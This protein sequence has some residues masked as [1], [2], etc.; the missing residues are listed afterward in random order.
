M[1]FEHLCN[2]SLPFDG[3]LAYDLMNLGEQSR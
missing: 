2:I 3:F 1:V